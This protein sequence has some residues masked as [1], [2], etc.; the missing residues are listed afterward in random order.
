MNRQHLGRIEKVI[1]AISNENFEMLWADQRGPLYEVLRLVHELEPAD[2]IPS[3][4]LSAF[5]K[6]RAVLDAW[7]AMD[8]SIPEIKD[9]LDGIQKIVQ[10][11]LAEPVPLSD[12]RFPSIKD[13]VLRGILDRDIAEAIA[14]HQLGQWKSCIVLCGSILEAALYEYLLRD[15]GW[16]MDKGRKCLPVY[17]GKTKDI[18]SDALEDQWKL[19]ELVDFA[20]ANGM[21]SGYK[22]ATIHDTL[23]QPRNLIH[24]MREHREDGRV[25]Q[26]TANVSLT[27]VLAVLDELSRLKDPPL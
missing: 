1:G 12:S 13:A 17:K 24:P 10:E 6:A 8:A 14:N 3:G 9:A 22:A 25:D 5:L 20:C 11:A 18:K 21:I 2:N 26:P 23:R 19:S 16:T 15:P 7:Q 27:M 4:K